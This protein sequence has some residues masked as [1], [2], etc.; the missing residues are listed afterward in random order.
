MRKILIL[1]ILLSSI[2]LVNFATTTSGTI[3]RNIN[4]ADGLI[5]SGAANGTNNASWE[6]D[7][8][9]PGFQGVVNWY[10]T[11]DDT[12]LYLGRLGGNNFEGTLVY[13]RA[14]KAGLTFSN[15]PQQY[16]N[17]SPNF[18]ALNGINFIAYLKQDYDEFRVFS[19]G[20]WTSPNTSLNPSFN[21]PAGQANSMEVAI[22]WNT[23][24][25]GNGKP[26]NLRAVLYQ[27]APSN[28][29]YGES[30]WGN[31]VGTN[32]P[33]IGV[34]DGAPTSDTQPGGSVGSSPSITRWWG[35][36][37][38][39]SGVGANGFIAQPPNAGA[40]ISICSSDN[41]IA[42][43]ANEPSAD[44]V[45]TWSL[46]QSPNGAN[47]IIV[48]PNQRN[49]AVT[50]F[51][52]N[53][54]YKFVWNINYGRCPAVPDTVV[55]TRFQAPID[56]AAGNDLVLDCGVNTA[57]LVGND[58]GIQQNFAGGIGNWSFAE[59]S[60]IIESSTTTQTNVSNL[61]IGS[62][63][64]V[65]SISNGSCPVQSDTVEIFRYEQVSASTLKSFSICGNSIFLQAN[66]PLQ[67]Q[68]TAV[69]TW[70]VVS[71]PN[72]P[73]FVNPN[74]FNTQLNSL[75]PGTY[76]LKW[77]VSNGNCLADSVQVNLT[78]NTGI[79]AEAGIDQS[80][81]G[82]TTTSLFANDVSASF[83]I[84]NWSQISGPNTANFSSITSNNPTLTNLVAGTYNFKWKIDSPGC[85]SD[86]DIVV[87]KVFA[88]PSGFQSSGTKTICGNQTSIS[89]INP[90]TIQNTATGVWTQI[91]GPSNANFSSTT[92]F[93]T[94][95]SNLNAGNYI[96][97]YTISNGSCEPS[98]KTFSLIVSKGVSVVI[99]SIVL[100]E[101]NQSNGSIELQVPINAAEPIEYSYNYTV[102]SS[103]L[104][105]SLSTGTYY[106]KIKD[107]AGCES[108]TL[109][110]LK[111]SFFIPT[112][113]SPNGDNMNE[114]WVIPGIEEFPN[115]SVQIFNQW[116]GIIYESKAG[117][118]VPWDGLYEGKKLPEAN[119]YYLI[120]L[121]DGSKKL[122]GKITLAR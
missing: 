92:N 97:N 55:I 54:I 49:S 61:A 90:T 73:Q 94:T 100:P 9:F 76:V 45:G 36:Y 13:L 11:W 1:I 17:F 34:N 58:P 103:E 30:P 14:D 64:L 107:N 60:G 31:G 111:N 91:T 67:I 113:I 21:T 19:S 75:V 89:L 74:L 22:P 32:G 56:A 88:N 40:D 105:D 81:C 69:G 116:G 51:T 41:S 106:I 109:I 33:N 70:S 71:G 59:G 79:Q 12:N 46:V 77:K 86:S 42:L 2:Q 68:S 62:N 78:V 28:F 85:P 16:D 39:I 29:V 5:V 72:T 122:N 57:V 50:N 20:N 48:N 3:I 93:S 10:L 6:Q 24:T 26:D 84:A 43:N 38:I 99:K 7:E 37:P 15:T 102:S 96:F 65:W 25:G 108:D 18:S 112:G 4:V 27:V 35:C 83:S 101:V 80:L 115:C 82:L 118:N 119:Y 53:G 98:A 95:V 52:E 110:N 8:V 87:V 44:A 104:L 63:K 120:D 23:I 47:P 117:Y 114:Q 121:G 66:D